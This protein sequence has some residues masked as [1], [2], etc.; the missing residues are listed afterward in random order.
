MCKWNEIQYLENVIF[1]RFMLNIVGRI[2]SPTV[3]GNSDL[4]VN[5]DC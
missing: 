4:V 3:D 2:L 1:P 5:F